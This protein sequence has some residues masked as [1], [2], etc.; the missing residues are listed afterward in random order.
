MLV[1]GNSKPYFLNFFQQIISAK[2]LSDA[3]NLFNDLSIKI[4]TNL[5]EYE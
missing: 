5:N 4:E 2:T 1:N 3:W